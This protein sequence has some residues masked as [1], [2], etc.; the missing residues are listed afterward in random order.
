MSNKVN[1]NNKLPKNQLKYLTKDFDAIIAEV[2]LLLGEAFNT[3]QE[4]TVFFLKDQVSELINSYKSLAFSL[5]HQTSL[6]KNDYQRLNAEKN[7]SQVKSEGKLIRK[8]TYLSNRERKINSEQKY[9]SKSLTRVK[10]LWQSNLGEMEKSVKT[11]KIMNIS[12]QQ[13]IKKLDEELAKCFTESR[14]TPFLLRVQEQLPGPSHPNISLPRSK[15]NS[16]SPSISMSVHSNHSSNDSIEFEKCMAE[17]DKLRPVPSENQSN[18]SI[19]KSFGGWESE[20]ESEAACTSGVNAEESKSAISILQKANL[21]DP[22]SGNILGK[23]SEA[24]LNPDS[25]QNIELLL[26]LLNMQGKSGCSPR[27][28][29]HKPNLSTSKYRR[30]RDDLACTTPKSRFILPEDFD[31]GRTILSS[32]NPITARHDENFENYE[33]SGGFEGFENSHNFNNYK[34]FENCENYENVENMERDRDIENI[35]ELSNSTKNLRKEFLREFENLSPS[36]AKA[37]PAKRII[38][39]TSDYQSTG[40]SSQTGLRSR[41]TLKTAGSEFSQKIYTPGS[42]GIGDSFKYL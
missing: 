19:D 30:L 17:Q 28:S 10:S 25:S 18:I 20:Y 32:E 15:P 23:L 37:G 27:L 33:H 3:P 40:I 24:V 35:S 2:D 26:Q 8:K 9:L 6:Y 36:G 1:E 14:K 29:I 13:N 12:L 31:M 16:R 5:K 39:G 21:L 7:K 34:G 41:I 38:Q 4:E 11:Q 22:H 42:K